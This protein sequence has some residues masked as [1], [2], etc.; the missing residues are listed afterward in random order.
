Q[1]S[2]DSLLSAEEFALGGS[3]FG[4]AYDFSELT[5]DD[6]L[7]ASIELRYG[8]TVNADLLKAFQFYGFYDFGAVWNDDAP[9][10]GRDTLA[11]AGG[12]V[13]L[14]LPRSVFTTLEVAKPLT[15][16]VSTTSDQDWRI[17]FSLS[18]SF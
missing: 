18:I 11:S 13:R 8:K 17:F 15:R 1:F 12:G 2:P 9:G 6:G 16:A 10:N 4:R 7:A 5:G 3:E 14:T